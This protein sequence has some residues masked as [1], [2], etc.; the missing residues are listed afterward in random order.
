ME[1]AIKALH[2]HDIVYGDLCDASKPSG[3]G[4]PVGFD[5]AGT[6]QVERYPAS[7]N[8]QANKW[9]PDVGRIVVMDKAHDVFMLEKL[10][11]RYA[12]GRV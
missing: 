3:G 5:W 2:E 8:N 11:K 1:A 7:W 9:S 10:K 12:K 4:M 6:H